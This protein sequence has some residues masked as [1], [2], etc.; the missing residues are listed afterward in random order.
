[1]VVA[2][3]DPV[4]NWSAEALC[5]IDTAVTRP[6]AVEPQSRLMDI[7]FNEDLLLSAFAGISV[8]LRCRFRRVRKHGRRKTADPA[9]ASSHKNMF[10]WRVKAR[11]KIERMTAL[12]EAPGTVVLLPPP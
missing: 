4:E 7:L 6:K 12:D 5:V 8:F 2:C 11:L 9:A 1:M 3:N 10:V